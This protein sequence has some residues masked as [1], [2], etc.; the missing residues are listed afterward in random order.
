MSDT[1]KV[2]PGSATALA[3]AMRGEDSEPWDGPKVRYDLV[4]EFV[5][6]LVVVLLLALGLAALLSS[7]D[8]H[9]V[10]IRQWADSSTSAYGNFPGQDFLVTAMTELDGSSPT[11]TYGP[12]YNPGPAAQKLL[13]LAPEKWAGVSNPVDPAEDYVLGPLAITAQHDPQLAAA[14]AQWNAASSEQQA[15]WTKSYEQALAD[16]KSTSDGQVVLAAGDYG[17]LPVM[18]DSLLGMAQSGALDNALLAS[19]SFYGTDYTKPLLFVADGG[20][21]SDLAQARHLQGD[22]WGM[23][24]ETGNYPGQ[25][26][27]W[28][29]TMWYQVWPFTHTGNADALVWGLMVLLTLV[30]LF[31]PLIPGLRSIPR[32]IPLYRA[33]WR[34]HYRAMDS[35]AGA[36]RRR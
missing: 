21:L 20:H 33:I 23:M 7:P 17:P 5:V 15:T 2:G 19:K 25:A 16:A 10:T 14:L 1:G 30:L 29:Y 24:N 8:D 9:S 3:D 35:E 11:A 4:K 34:D 28:L 32:W 27:L 36:A 6:A 18:M 26:W 31:L 12:P 13:F 22:Q